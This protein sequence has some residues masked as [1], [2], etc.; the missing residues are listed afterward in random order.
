MFIINQAFIIRRSSEL[1]KILQKKISK[2]LNRVY[3]LLLILHKN[4]ICFE[5]F[6]SSFHSKA[7]L[8]LFII[9]DANS[10]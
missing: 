6:L 1:K 8:L 9:S 3:W 2:A 4:C 7:Y 10:N 5:N